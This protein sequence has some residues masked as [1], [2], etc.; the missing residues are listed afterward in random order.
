MRY[1]AGVGAQKAG[2]TWLHDQLATHPEVALPARKEV[3]YFDMVTAHRGGRS[4]GLHYLRQLQRAAIAGQQGR[5]RDL[6]ELLSLS[7]E[8]DQG[9]RAYLSKTATEQTRVT[10]EITPAYAC[11]TD[12]GFTRLAEALHQPRII[13]IMRDPL[14]RYWSSVRMFERD[15]SLLPEAFAT[16]I[17]RQGVWA[18]CD[19]SAT[20]TGL[21]RNFSSDNVLYLFYESL[22]QERTLMQVARFLRV[23]ERWSWDIDRVS[24]P[25]PAQ[26]MPDPPGEVVERLRVVYDAVRQR[27]GDQ[28]PDSWAEL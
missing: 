2:T 9:Y 18:R 5:V 24:N 27:F 1:F 3:H 13:F 16:L 21:E 8:G 23:E 19:Y 15:P 28:V 11:L 17:Q 10:G 4:F 6:T 25:G 12:A 20:L 14:A 26:V 7:F 22:F